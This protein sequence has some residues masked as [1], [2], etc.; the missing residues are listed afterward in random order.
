MTPPPRA[1]KGR[2]RNT[3]LLPVLLTLL[4]PGPGA[5]AQETPDAPREA[6][7]PAPTSV[8][9][10]PTAVALDDASPWSPRVGLRLALGA[11]DGV[12]LAALLQP[13]PWLRV[14]LG[15]ARNSLGTTLQAGVELLPIQ[16]VVSPVVGLGYGHAFALDYPGLLSRLHG[17]PTTPGTALRSVAAEQ[18]SAT[19]GLEFSP[20]RPVTISGGLGVGYWFIRVTDTP[21]FIREAGEDPT[22]TSTP[23]R[24]GLS[25]PV[26]RLAVLLY[27]N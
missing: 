27:F 22:I 13:R 23:L 9:A 6:G 15:G 17:T 19:V 26:A 5:W 25:T 20:W 2:A 16:L 4:T 3:C 10:P 7:V 11:P 8:P 14:Q 1:G 18:L 12:A 24:L 21:A